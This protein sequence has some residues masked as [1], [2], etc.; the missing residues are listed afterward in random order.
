MSAAEGDDRR[1]AARLRARGIKGD[2]FLDLDSEVRFV[3]TGGMMVRLPLAPDV[4]SVH[5][6]SLD[7]GGQVLNLKGVVRNFQA[8]VR[9]GG[10]PAYDVGI[11]FEN[12]TDADR[13]F[14]ADF[15]VRHLTS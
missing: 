2:L 10:P 9:D 14:L 5:D 12:L 3:S 4:G 6:F 1:S 13:A 8:I 15:V 11:E 7:F